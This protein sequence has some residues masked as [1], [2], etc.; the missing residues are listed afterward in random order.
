MEVSKIEKKYEGEY[1]NLFN[2]TFKDKETQHEKIYEIVSRDKE[3]KPEEFG[4]Q[5]RL[6]TKADGVGIIAINTINNIEYIL[7]EKEFRMSVG[8]FIYN[9]P[10]GLIDDGETAEIAAERE[11]REETGVH[12]ENIISVI[13]PAYTAIG[14]SNERVSTVIC[15]ASGDI[16]NSE[17]PD[18][19]IEAKW[20]TKEEIREI[21][22]N[23]EPMSLRTQTL[24]YMWANN[25]F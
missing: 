21:I 2:I 18:E 25:G 17:D 24:L 15:T 9:I 5:L 4:R 22:N 20:Y 12:L 8:E 13:P 16:V 14:F 11:L 19:I 3:L 10:G 23:N 6:N 1:I 7:L